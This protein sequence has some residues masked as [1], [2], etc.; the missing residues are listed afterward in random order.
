MIIKNFFLHHVDVSN[1]NVTPI[2]L[3]LNPQNLQDYVEEL[4]SEIIA[5]PNRRI[6]S[7]KDGNTEVKSSLRKILEDNTDVENITE[8]NAKRLLEK[9]INTQAWMTSRNM[10]VEIQKGSLLHLNFDINGTKQIIICKVE[11]DEILNELNFEKVRGLNT[12]KKVFKAIL[13]IFNNR[14]KIS[15]NYV[16]D[17]HN[18]K[19]WWD[20]FLELQQQYTDD[21]NT[22]KSLNAIDA[23]LTPLRNK[24]YAD[25]VILRNTIIGYYKNNDSLNYSDVISNVVQNYDPVNVDFPKDAL[26]N[27]LN[28]LP[29]KKGFDTQFSIVKKK[30]NKKVKHRIK[31][32]NNLYLSMDD[33]VDNLRNILKPWKDEQGNKY[34]QILSS[35]GFD[36]IEDLMRENG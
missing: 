36:K 20:D 13:I 12:K 3:Q 16:F 5:N 6:Y 1:N 17:K 4:L 28:E 31:L 35:E 21:D 23:T 10:S 32:A 19:Y 8:L 26:I 2:N 33:F 29:A 14:G 11:H 24:F 30:I 22:E 9:E 34:V 27:K 15:E 18:S 7:F 25:Y